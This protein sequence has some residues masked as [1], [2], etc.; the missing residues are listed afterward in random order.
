M[1]FDQWKRR[2][3]ITLLGGAAA[4]VI[5]PILAPMPSKD[6]FGFVQTILLNPHRKRSS[7][8]N[9]RLRFVE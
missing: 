7:V 5:S 4:V 8:A 9:R 6:G 2:E 1:Q 3:F